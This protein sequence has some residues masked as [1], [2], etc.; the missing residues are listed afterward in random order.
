MN[1]NTY[2]DLK[3]FISMT[4]HTFTHSFIDLFLSCF[5]LLKSF[6]VHRLIFLNVLS[7]FFSFRYF[8]KMEA[9]KSFWREN[10]I[11]RSPTKLLR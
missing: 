4:S 7:Y 1:A 6:F 2:V 3:T 10:R 9:G 11:D 8:L 5:S